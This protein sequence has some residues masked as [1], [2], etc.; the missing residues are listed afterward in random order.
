MSVKLASRLAGKSDD[1]I[2]SDAAS[3]RAFR[4]HEFF[5]IFFARIG[6][7]HR[8]QDARGAGLNR[9]MDVVAD[10]RKRID[11]RDDIALKIA[12]CEVVNRTRR[13]P[14]TAATAQ[15]DALEAQPRG[16]G[17]RYEFTV[18]PSN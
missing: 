7:L 17:S 8:A 11:G 3:R 2:C 4:I 13:I 10:R 12:G 5:E 15:Q 9:Q 16:E 1:H 14:G 6:A 18:C